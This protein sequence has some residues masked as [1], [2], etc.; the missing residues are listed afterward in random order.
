[1]AKERGRTARV[2]RRISLVGLLVVLLAL[3]P[4]AAADHE[5]GWQLLAH[6]VLWDGVELRI[7]QEP[8]PVRY[9][10]VHVH[11]NAPV[12][13]KPIV[14]GGR[15]GSVREVVSSMCSR[16]GA[17]ACVNANFP[18]CPR[19]DVPHGAVVRKH[20]LLQT[21]TDHQYQLKIQ[22]GRFQTGPIPWSARLEAVRNGP[23]D[24][25]A[26]NGINIGTRRDQIVLHNRHFGPSTGSPPGTVELVLRAP[27]P[28]WTGGVRQQAALVRVETAGNAR[29]PRNGA[30]LSGSGMGAHVLWAYAQTNARI[31]VDLV[32][33]SPRGLE[34]AVS[35]HPTLTEGGQPTALDP[36]DD[37]VVNLHP[38]TLVGWDDQGSVWFVVVDGRQAHSRGQT[39]DESRELLARLGARWVMNMDGGGSSTMVSSCAIGWCVRNRPSDGRERRVWVGLAVVPPHRW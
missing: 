23:P 30:V 18:V 14:S 17:I 27:T 6:D 37:K 28:L 9:H 20:E 26:I 8:G 16:T 3:G 32:V 24:V 12:R 15:L 7:V 22:D 1:M 25:L 29:I 21:P 35:G 10:V 4:P 13:F 31:P 39:L 19:C 34:M 2:V 33:E 5:P 36:A 11:P 38:R